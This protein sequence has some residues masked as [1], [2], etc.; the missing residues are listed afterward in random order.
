MSLV[1]NQIYKCR[2]CGAEVC[3]VTVSN[4]ET[5]SYDMDNCID[6]ANAVP[7]M[8]KHLAPRLYIK[9]YCKNGDLGVADFIG[10]EKE[11]L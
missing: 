9:H 11:E 8:P 7:F 2:K 3:P 1:Y 4:R 6:R 10:Y 5:A